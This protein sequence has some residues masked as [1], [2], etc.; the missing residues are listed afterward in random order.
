VKD[1]RQAAG[2]VALTIVILGIGAF[3]AFGLG[4]PHGAARPVSTGG[5]SM[6]I[7]NAKQLSLGFLMYASDW[8]DRMP[9]R[10][11]DL[12]YTEI[13]LDPYLRNRSLWFSPQHSGARYLP[14][15]ELTAVPLVEMVTDPAV[16]VLLY[17]S[18]EW[19]DG[20]RVVAYTDG[21]AKPLAGFDPKTDVE[22]EL[23]Q[24]GRDLVA[25]AKSAGTIAQT[26]QGAQKPLGLP[27]R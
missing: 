24:K 6:S 8:D 20:R 21:H 4:G 27:G 18:E 14:N 10:M 9:P 22:V 7:S 19:S 11:E 13:V 17:E 25:R 26:A 16:A 3:V 15:K 12:R 1:V 5:L 2:L 23:T